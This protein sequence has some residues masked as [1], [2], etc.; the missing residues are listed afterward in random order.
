MVSPSGL[1]STEIHEPSSVSSDRVRAGSSGRS[2]EA[3]VSPASWAVG[4]TRVI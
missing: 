3:D 1:T 2:A 4:P